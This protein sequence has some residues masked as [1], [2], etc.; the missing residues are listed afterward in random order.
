MRE[1]VSIQLDRLSPAAF[2]FLV[3]GAVLEQDATFERLCRVADL[4]EQEGLVA[5]DEVL[6]SLLVQ[7]PKRSNGPSGNDVYTF[8]HP[9]IREVVYV[10][11]GETRS[12]IFHRRALSILQDTSIPQR[13]WRIMLWQQGC[14]DPAFRLSVVAGD[15]ARAVFAL[16]VA[17]EHYEQAW[18]LLATQRTDSKVK[19]RSMTSD[20]HHLYSAL[21]HAYELTRTGEQARPLYADH[22]QPSTQ[23]GSAGR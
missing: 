8:T 21:G 18:Q 6:R 11:A 20:V 9:M 5:L 2:A 22:A 12:R 3:A 7:E 1:L 13:N 10:E 14:S 23:N 17:I 4:S 15:E 19:Q 16:D